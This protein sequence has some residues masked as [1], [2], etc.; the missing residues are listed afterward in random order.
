MIGLGVSYEDLEVKRGTVTET[1][2]QS[3]LTAKER[4]DLRFD[5]KDMMD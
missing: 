4:S 5:S 2:V 3:Q 1:Q